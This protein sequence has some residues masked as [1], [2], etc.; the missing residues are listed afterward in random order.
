MRL[1]R[2]TRDGKWNGDGIGSCK[3]VH[4]LL[5]VQAFSAREFL[6][7]I[8]SRDL[9]PL[10]PQSQPHQQR[11]ADA[12]DQPEGG[13]PQRSCIVVSVP[14]QGTLKDT[15]AHAHGVYVSVET[16][17]ELEDG[18][19]EV[20]TACSVLCQS[21]PPL[22]PFPPLLFSPII[23]ANACNPVQ[24]DAGG[25]IPRWVQNIAM[26]GQILGDGQKFFKF[27]REQQRR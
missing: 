25:S 13:G 5:H 15:A 16:V 14:R 17:R 23:V 4:K 6:E 21:P 19:V 8:V 9:P 3:D 18:T 12:D 11:P 24:S 26:A 2:L 7:T 1:V 10:Q 27:V 20:T 22:P